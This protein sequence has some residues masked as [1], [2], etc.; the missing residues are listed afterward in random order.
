MQTLLRKYLFILII[1]ELNIKCFYCFY[2][3]FKK[4]NTYRNIL[5]NRTWAIR[6]HVVYR[7]PCV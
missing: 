2:F 3:M 4:T 1:V 6:K 5:N 7:D